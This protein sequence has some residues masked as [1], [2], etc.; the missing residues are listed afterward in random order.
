M[1]LPDDVLLAYLGGALNPSRMYDL[2]AELE[3]SPPLRARL[4][5]LT[6]ALAAAQASAPRPAP[7]AA[8]PRGAAWRLPPPGRTA[9]AMAAPARW[10]LVGVMDAAVGPSVGDRVRL[11]FEAPGEPADWNVVVLWRAGGDWE[12]LF[13]ASA[14]ELFRPVELPEDAS[15]RRYLDAVIRDPAL[16]QRW[17]V[18]LSPAGA[19]IDWSLPPAA[20]WAP[21]IAAAARGEAPAVTVEVALTR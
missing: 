7:L 11:S 1:S 6:A 5:G 13:P 17:A 12:V 4:Q 3:I 8:P 16:R 19:A 2:E 14:E 18:V 10:A 20:R 9:G 21:L 15:G